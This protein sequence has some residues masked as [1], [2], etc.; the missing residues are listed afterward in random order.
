MG[1]FSVQKCNFEARENLQFVCKI[2]HESGKN[3]VIGVDWGKKGGS[4]G[5][6]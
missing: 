5:V 6:M 2:C 3:G 4:L 1:S